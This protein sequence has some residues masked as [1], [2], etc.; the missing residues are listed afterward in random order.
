MD[1]L[2]APAGTTTVVGGCVAALFDQTA[3][4]APLLGA[5]PLRVTAPVTVLPPRAEEELKDKDWSDELPTKGLY[6]AKTSE[7]PLVSL[8]TRLLAAEA[9]ITVPPPGLTAVSLQQ[10]YVVAFPGVPS[11]ATVTTD[12]WFATVSRIIV[13]SIPMKDT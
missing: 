3:T 13:C 2:V 8:A 4:V 6:A 12:V 11:L 7:T 1:A 5:G 9:K 10:K